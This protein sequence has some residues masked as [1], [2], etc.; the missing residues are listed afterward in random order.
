MKISY[1]G[2]IKMRQKE[3]CYK[4]KNAYIYIAGGGRKNLSII[5][6]IEE[7]CLQKIYL[8]DKKKI[9]GDF[10]ESQAFAYLAVRCLKKL[11][12]TFPSTTGVKKKI[13][14]GKIY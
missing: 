3:F 4:N 10:I 9:N 14:G 1:G 6:A 13:S 12:I 2:Y 11:P 5:K 7:N 8:I